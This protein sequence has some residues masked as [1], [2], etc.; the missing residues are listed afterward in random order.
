MTLR[1]HLEGTKAGSERGSVTVVAASLLLMLG[2]LMLGVTDVG[3][4]L[5]A[6]EQ[7]QT[8]ADAAALA[9]AEE[10]ALPS[11]GTPA[12]A[13]AAEAAANH[14]QLVT[15][16]CQPGDLEAVVDVSAS[17]DDLSLLPGAHVIHVRARAVVDSGAAI[18]SPAAS[19]SP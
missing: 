11:D 5:A 14:A 17:L 6:R 4:V 16:A 1:R 3:R 18:A 9:A 15:C 7:A 19:P 8:A 2:V 10:L 12:E 13:A